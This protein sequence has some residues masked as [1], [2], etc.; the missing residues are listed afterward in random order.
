[1]AIVEAAKGE[2]K[3]FKL[4]QHCK[5]CQSQALT[6]VIKIAPQFLSPTFIRNNVEEGDLAKIQVP[7]TM[8]LCDLSRNS[9]GCGLLQLR[10]EVEADLLYRRYFYR[11]ATSDMMRN[12]LKDVIRDISSRVM[13]KPND[14]VVDI[15]ANDCT[16]LG[17]Y[18]SN[19]RRVAYEPARNIDWSG[20]DPSITIINDY[21]SAPPFKKRF[22]GEKAI[23]VGC[24]A[25]FYDL[26]DPNL[27]TTDVKSILAPE[28]VWCIQ[29]SY[30]PLMLTN[31]NFYDICH[32]H[33]S[34]YSLDALQ[35][36]MRR[37][38][39]AIFDASTNNVNGGSLRAFVTHIENKKAFTAAGARNLK[40]LADHETE[41]KLT[42]P[43]TYRTYY[44]QI[45]D[46]ATRVNKFVDG[47]IKNGGKVFGLGAS[48][49]GNVLLQ[50]FGITKD[51][52]PYISERNPDKVGLRTL[53]T[54]FELISEELARELG[55]SSMLVLPWYF[56]KEI[57]AREKPYLDQGGK[58][59][60][61][62]PYAHVVTKNGEQR[63]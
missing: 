45:E 10:E 6:D 37:N 5:V 30:L 40:T 2:A 15:G 16:T 14:L 23:A 13:L 11:S 7:F 9:E 49:K 53:G 28:G 60:F 8:T 36:L 52:M 38:G 50:F 56:K 46:L 27:F 61:P 48:T 62:M 21:F 12:D 31:M 34:Y 4:L 33:L 19:L 26:A 24:N 54:D 1:M 63:L 18:P 51:K 17:F 20:V 55:P 57:V 39:L 32:E 29:L 43:Q 22:Q 58:L 42:E 3:R 59:I 25:M 44:N 35:R 47:E 41:L